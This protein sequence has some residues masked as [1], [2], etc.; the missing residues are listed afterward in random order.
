MATLINQPFVAAITLINCR[1]ANLSS[2]MADLTAS[3]MIFSIFSKRWVKKLT[4]HEIFNLML[5]CCQGTIADCK[6][7]LRVRFL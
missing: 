6:S 2:K 4:E 7:D 1:F 5:G 3:F